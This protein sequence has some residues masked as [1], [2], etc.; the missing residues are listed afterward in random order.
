MNE[1]WILNIYNKLVNLEDRSGRNNLRIDDT[2]EK[3]CSFFFGEKLES[4]HKAKKA[5]TVK[6]N[7]TRTTT[8][9][10]LNYKDKKNIKK[11][12]ES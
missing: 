7:Q 4:V 9:R 6:Q 8:C 11:I 3:R 10:L 12:T 2:K 1:S 5:K